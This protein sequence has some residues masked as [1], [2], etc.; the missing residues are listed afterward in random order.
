MDKLKIIRKHYYTLYNEAK[1][2]GDFKLADGYHS[3]YKDFDF[4]I[5]KQTF[6]RGEWHGSFK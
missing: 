3:K 5:K 6:M 4:A 1:K 2:R